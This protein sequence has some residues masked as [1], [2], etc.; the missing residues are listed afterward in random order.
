MMSN[1]LRYILGCVG[2][3]DQAIARGDFST[4]RDIQ[5]DL[6]AGD[7]MER[8]VGAVIVGNSIDRARET[9]TKQVFERRAV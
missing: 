9:L 4:A 7:F 8:E 3:A 6:A 2:E 1:E 5:A